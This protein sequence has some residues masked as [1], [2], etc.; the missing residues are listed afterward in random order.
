MA[1]SFEFVCHRTA[2]KCKEQARPSTYAE[3]KY[4][5]DAKLGQ[6]RPRYGEKRI[7]ELSCWLMQICGTSLTTVRRWFK[8][9]DTLR[10]VASTTDTFE[11][12]SIEA[13]QRIVIPD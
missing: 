4:R 8:V 9:A 11:R 6:K 2:S 3:I 12:P 5:S 7:R 13:G 1:T 10:R